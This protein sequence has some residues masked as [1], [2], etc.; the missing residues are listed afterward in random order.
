MPRVGTLST[1]VE[2]P[3]KGAAFPQSKRRSRRSSVR[4]RRSVQCENQGSKSEVLTNHFAG[5]TV[6][7]VCGTKTGSRT[8][9]MIR[10]AQVT[11]VAVLVLLGYS[12]LSAQLIESDIKSA[13]DADAYLQGELLSKRIPGMSIC[14]VRNGKTVLA[15]GYGF[16][17]LELSVPASE[18]TI[19]ELASL[20]KPFTATAVMMLVEAGKISLEDRPAEVFPRSSH[21]LG[22][23]LCG[24]TTPPYIGLR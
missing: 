13:R 2:I 9:K 23:R 3:G 19:Y 15:R 20:T 18:D 22:K 24:A 21:E 17:N 4:S 16:A 6:K 12:S 11:F 7:G 14:V 1:N 8:T 5:W 10:F